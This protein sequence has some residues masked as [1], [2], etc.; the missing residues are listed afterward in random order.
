MDDE[1]GRLFLYLSGF[2]FSELF[3]D[4]FEI[5][6][7]I[8]KFSYYTILLSVSIILLVFVL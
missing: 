5:K 2:G 8:A 6:S 3:L 7:N 1:I 4:Y